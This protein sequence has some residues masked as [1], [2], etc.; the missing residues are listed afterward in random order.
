MSDGPFNCIVLFELNPL[1]P[2]TVLTFKRNPID[3]NATMLKPWYAYHLAK[4]YGNAEIKF[5][6]FFPK[7]L[8]WLRPTERFLTKL[9]F[10][11]LYATIIKKQ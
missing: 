7:I 1:N 2:L 3:Q 10:G 11:A 5:Y 9:P 6:C 8:K 4:N